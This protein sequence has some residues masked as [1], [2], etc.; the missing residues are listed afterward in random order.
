MP[1]A[2]LIAALPDLV[3]LVRR[4]GI[5]LEHGAGPG[6]AGL[7]P[8]DDWINRRAEAVWPESIAGLVVQLTRKA[9][10]QRTTAEARFQ[11]DGRE[12]EARVTPQGP[13]R[14]LCVMRVVSVDAQDESLEA[15]DERLPPQLDR[16]GF[17]QRFRE[18]LSIAALREDP[19]ALAV[20][21]LD[22]ISD[23]AQIIAAKTAEQI[24]SAAILR[25]PPQSDG[26]VEGVPKW[27]LG[28]LSD[29]LLA[30]VLMSSDR[31]AIDACVSRVSASLREPV[32]VAGSVFRLTPS[33]GV[34]ILGQDASSPKL[35]LEHARAAA[36]EARSS[37]SARVCFFTDTLGLT[38]LSRLDIA[39]ELQR[40]I[41]NRDI[42]LRYVG[43]HD[44]QTGRLISCVGYLHWLHPLRGEIRPAEFLRVAEATGLAVTL[45]RVVLGCLQEDFAEL[46]SH[47]EEDVCISFGA[48]RHHILH[49]SFVSDIERFL[50]VGTVPAQR[51]ELRI[52]ERTFITR[53]PIELSALHRLGVKLVVDE[54][55]RGMGS[56]DW[57][58]RAPIWG[59][60]LDRA[61]TSALRVDEV[62]HKVCRAGIAVATS[63]GLTPIAT[64]VDN[65]QQRDAL[66]SLGCRL[67]AGDLYRHSVPNITSHS[68]ELD[69]TAPLCDAP[70]KRH[71]S[72]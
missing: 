56:L 23:I 12:H 22:G 15:A 17:L 1:A 43:R 55:A 57:L 62:A 49:D 61:W 65:T 6:I 8:A 50:A 3:V 37:A 64:G 5:I 46:A 39:R 33:V 51:L 4:D 69:L 19:I 7:K 63:L 44:L 68:G 29:N 42:R 18:S 66:L 60:Q 38:T 30:L 28:Q 67:G 71:S 21:H 26:T 25:L 2:S 36:S 41:A 54:V 34:A 31:A 53:E 14:A 13:D 72:A 24:M 32:S 45:S 40:A 35:L 9:I 16:R 47:C 27:Y 59:L 52:A 10:A 70:H 11:H 48:L 20:I 58:A